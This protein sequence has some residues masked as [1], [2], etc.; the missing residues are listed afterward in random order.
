LSPCRN[1][2]DKSSA[3]A[4]WWIPARGDLRIYAW[5]PIHQ[6]VALLSFDHLIGLLSEIPDPRRREGK[7]YQLPYVLLFSILAVVT[8][9]IRIVPSKPSSRC[10]AAG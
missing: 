5:Q 1:I 3:R 6:E 4:D 8:G 9:A 10:T 2:G 7:L